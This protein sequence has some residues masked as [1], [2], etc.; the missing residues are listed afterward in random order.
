MNDLGRVAS[1]GVEALRERDLDALVARGLAVLDERLSLP[2]GLV[3]QP[4]TG[5][6][7][8]T[9]RAARGWSPDPV[10]RLLATWETGSLAERVIGDGFIVHRGTATE[11]AAG[12]AAELLRAHGIR[13]GLEVL[14][15]GPDAL[16]GVLGLFT[17]ERRDFTVDEVDFARSLALTIAAV[18]A[19]RETEEGLLRSQQRLQT[20]QK[21]EAIGRL[22]GGIAHDFNNLVQAIG[23]YTDMLLRQLPA[24]A[25]SRFHVEEI[26]R[27]GERA[28]A[29]TRQLLAFSR[30]QVLQP[31]V[32][33]VNDVV[34]N[35]QHLLRRLVG[36]QVL[37]DF[38]LG[39]GLGSVRADAAQLEQ[40]LINL[41]VNARD[42]MPGGGR[43][44]IETRNAVLP[45]P[46][47]PETFI[48]PGPY[49][50][51]SV[52]DSGHGM[53]AETRR[54]AFEPFFT[55]KPVGHGTG[56]GLSTVY[57]V[58]KQSGG[59]IL[60][61]SALGKGSTFRVYLPKV[62]DA[63]DAVVEQ[64]VGVV[65]PRRGGGETVLLVEDEDAVRDLI[66]EWLGSHG[67]LVVAAANSREAMAA[68]ASASA[69]IDVLV[70][71]VVMPG[72]GGPELASRIR[73][74]QPGL[75][76]V[77][78]SGYADDAVDD[79][80]LHAEGARFL[81]KP[82]PLDALLGKVREVLDADRGETQP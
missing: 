55:T 49:V 53:D 50:L 77:Y 22:A 5:S 65:E 70:A 71:D 40:V 31:R 24:D 63:P 80:R 19:R 28:A 14:L 68:V 8:V 26:R 45:A 37:L 48:K 1:F 17:T 4:H 42:A 67:Y 74:R 79:P 16:S 36:E 41:A 58:V 44:V 82:F 20:V 6:S 2:F 3:L 62:E 32:L 52:G 13:S 47:Q 12:E 30:Q 76:V 34:G 23:G 35:L 33:A 18:M 72:I 25:A 43:L 46:D 75:R 9:I 54:R 56:L 7:L 81:Q 29:L 38:R 51:L 39:E 21:M 57:G 59:Y 11:A 69:P 27:A 78:M 66:A 10:G 60:L 73:P 64:R 15:P 61:D